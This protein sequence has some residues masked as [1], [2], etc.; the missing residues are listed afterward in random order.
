[1]SAPQQAPPFFRKPSGQP[2]D[3]VLLDTWS[4]LGSAPEKTGQPPAAALVIPRMGP[5]AGE[6]AFT[7]RPVTAP[8]GRYELQLNWFPPML[9]SSEFSEQ[10]FRRFATSSEAWVQEIS[11]PLFGAGNPNH[12]RWTRLTV[13]TRAAPHTEEDNR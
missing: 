12:G 2:V 6:R 10:E 9:L 8:S 1:M 7:L 3:R 4:V 5:Q 13:I 11:L